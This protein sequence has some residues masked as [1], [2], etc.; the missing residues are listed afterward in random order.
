[1]AA[2][3]IFSR[4]FPLPGP[5]SFIKRVVNISDI[6]MAAEKGL[7]VTNELGKVSSLNSIL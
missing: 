1:M 6:N 4:S 3:Y 5:F 2:R 7:E